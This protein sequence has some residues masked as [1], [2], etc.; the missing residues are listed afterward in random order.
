MEIEIS[1][2][3]KVANSFQTCCTCCYK[4][5]LDLLYLLLQI[6]FRCELHKPLLHIIFS[7]VATTLNILQL[8]NMLRLLCV[9]HSF[10]CLLYL[11]YRQFLSLLH[12]LC[13]TQFFLSAVP[14]LQIILVFAA[15]MLH[16]VFN[17]AV[18]TVY[19]LYTTVSN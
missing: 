15:G 6:V 1:E 7:S 4:Q 13:Y 10:F 16:M 19:I 9:T 17:P 14:L 8:L 11:C 3:K 5:F 18:P 12:L 2:G